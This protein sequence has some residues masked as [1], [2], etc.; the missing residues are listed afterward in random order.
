MEWRSRLRIQQCAESGKDGGRTCVAIDEFTE[1]L[2]AHLALFAVYFV[3]H[4]SCIK[5]IGYTVE[6]EQNP[7]TKDDTV[8]SVPN[9]GQKR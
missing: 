1:G 4:K 5:W 3:G 7:K 8:V 6:R 9:T 2:A